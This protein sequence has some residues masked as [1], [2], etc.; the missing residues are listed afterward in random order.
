MMKILLLV[1]A[2]VL[3]LAN[4]FLL[5]VAFYFSKNR[6]DQASKIGFG[7]MELLSMGNALTIG[8]IVLCLA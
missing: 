2:V 7:F 3:V 6:K 4:L 8:G 5:G 1:W